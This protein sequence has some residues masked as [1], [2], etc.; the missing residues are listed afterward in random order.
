MGI[1]MGSSRL[2]HSFYL[3]I[4]INASFDDV[5]DL[6]KAPVQDRANLF[7]LR[8]GMIHS[9]HNLLEICLAEFVVCIDGSPGQAVD[10]L[11][12]GGEGEDGPFGGAEGEFRPDGRY[13]G[14]T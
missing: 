7:V 9:L 10:D 13:D 3:L 2:A 12:E 14:V 5:K 4:L 8:Q 11:L 6:G 1:E